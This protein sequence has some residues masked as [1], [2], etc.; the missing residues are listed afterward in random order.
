MTVLKTMQRA[1]KR[2]KVMSVTMAV[3]IRCTFPASALNEEKMRTEH[4][5]T[6]LPPS[7]RRPVSNRRTC[8]LVIHSQSLYIGILLVCK[9]AGL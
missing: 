4:S 2:S 6:K 9:Y 3:R 8:M 1:M 7:C 5:E